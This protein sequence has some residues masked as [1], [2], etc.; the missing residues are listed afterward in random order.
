MTS[1]RRTAVAL[2]GIAAAVL[3]SVTGASASAAHSADTSSVAMA[4]NPMDFIW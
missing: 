3:V 2:L 4:A 1:I